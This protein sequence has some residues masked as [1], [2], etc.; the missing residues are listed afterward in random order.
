MMDDDEPPISDEELVRL[1]RSRLPLSMIA[2]RFG[3][4]RE[5]IAQRWRE[6]VRAGDLP[7]REPRSIDR[8]ALLVGGRPIAAAPAE[9]P[10]PPRPRPD[11][12]ELVTPP[13]PPHDGLLELLRKCHPE[14]DPG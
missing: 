6:L 8:T 9:P 14:R 4:P 13:A 7:S 5:F 11:D 1:W 12:D 2:R 3:V 10:P